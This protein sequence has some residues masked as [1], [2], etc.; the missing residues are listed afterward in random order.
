LGRSASVVTLG[1]R[2]TTCISALLRDADL[3]LP[4]TPPTFIATSGAAA[5]M[6]IHG[7]PTLL[8]ER[9]IRLRG[10]VVDRGA[11]G[12]GG[13][14]FDPETPPEFASML[15]SKRTPQDDLGEIVDRL[16]AIMDD[17]VRR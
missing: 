12:P 6:R 15:A 3:G 5:A 1:A 17:A 13:V 14:V 8:I 10:V 7:L 11:F 16:L 2:S 4:S 9:G